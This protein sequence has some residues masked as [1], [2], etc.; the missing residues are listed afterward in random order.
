MYYLGVEEWENM[1]QDEIDKQ[2]NKKNEGNIDILSYDDEN[3]SKKTTDALCKN[4]FFIFLTN[5]LKGESE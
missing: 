2:S 3:D 5:T 1:R 4:I